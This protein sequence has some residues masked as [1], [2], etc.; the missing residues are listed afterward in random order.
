MHYQ[1]KIRLVL[2]SLLT[3]AALPAIAGAAVPQGSQ[4]ELE[5]KLK[6]QY[7]AIESEIAAPPSHVDHPSDYRDVLRAWQDRLA[8]RFS[9]AAVTAEALMQVDTGNADMW[10][11]RMETLRVYGKPISSPRE[12]SVFGP[13]EV[14]KRFKVIKAPAAIY[15]D[16]ARASNIRG[17]V[18]LR[19]IMAADGKVMNVFPIKSLSHGLTESAM[20]AARQIQF[21]PAERNGEVVSQFATFVYEF[22]KADATPYIPRTVF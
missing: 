1:S 6:L 17:E 12:R 9:E 21:T 22:R 15:T 4:A 18:R 13:G 10:R 20:A 7:A 16:E 5:Q 8:S 14:Q 2:I 11:E 3:V 19:V